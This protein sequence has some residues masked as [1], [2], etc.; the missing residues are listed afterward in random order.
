MA[1]QPNTRLKLSAPVPNESG[2]ALELRNDRLS[3]MN[4]LSRRRSLGAIR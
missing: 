2:C 1:V 3:V 4:V